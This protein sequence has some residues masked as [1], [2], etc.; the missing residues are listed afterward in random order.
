[1][2]QFWSLYLRNAFLGLGVA[3]LA[4]PALITWCSVISLV[5]AFKRQRPVAGPA[6]RH[7]YW[8]A[9]A[10]SLF[11]PAFIWVS[12]AGAY[13]YEHSKQSPVA[14]WSIPIGCLAAVSLAV[15][16]IYQMKGLRWFAASLM[17]VQ[18]G[19]V[20]GGLGVA[21]LTTSGVFI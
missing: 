15:F 20:L 7:Y 13:D 17:G 4:P 6:W 2:S 1:M 19:V 5:W 12:V 21:V 18:L 3:F 11:F 9:L 10:E 8:L 16:W 14:H